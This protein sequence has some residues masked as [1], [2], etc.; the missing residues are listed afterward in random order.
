MGEPCQSAR[1]RASEKRNWAERVAENEPAHELCRRNGRGGGRRAS[2]LPSRLAWG[3]G[4][5]WPRSRETAA[6]ERSRERKRRR[7]GAPPDD[8]HRLRRSVAATAAKRAAAG[9]ANRE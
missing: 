1:T 7:A 8:L 6:R 3:A 5:R 2:T 9:T 4:R